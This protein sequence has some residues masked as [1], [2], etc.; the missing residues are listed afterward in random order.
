MLRSRLVPRFGS[1]PIRAIAPHD[2]RAF[3]AELVHEGLSASRIRQCRQV[4]S[5]SLN[6]AVHDGRIAR[7][8]VDGAKVPTDRPR[9]PRYLTRSGVV[10]LASAAERHRHGAGL[11]VLVLGL[12]GMRWGELVA[13][14]VAAVD[15]VNHR[16]R[17][18]ASATEVHGKLI[19]GT[20]KTHASRSI[21]YPPILQ[22][23]SGGSCR[24]RPQTS[25]CSRHDAAGRCV[26]RDSVWG[27][28]YPQSRKPGMNG[29]GCM[30][31]GIRPR[32]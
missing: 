25:W 4:L 30:I 9:E 32:R 13:L 27:C 29:S 14:Q 16:I 24:R 10:E 28:G 2:I 8:P 12:T 1:T 21:S 17:V 20:P 19:F 3:V 11:I 31:C 7:N 5:A 23:T 18:S 15:L 26:T 22:P 6:Q